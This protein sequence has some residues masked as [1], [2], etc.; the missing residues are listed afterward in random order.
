MFAVSIVGRA[1]VALQENSTFVP[2]RGGSYAEGIIGQPVALNPIISSN[3]T[4]QDISS[5]IYSS[6]KDLLIVTEPTEEGRVYQ[7]KLKNDLVWDDG[8][9]LT[10]DDVLFTIRTVQD[11]QARSPFAQEWQGIVAERISE[12]QIKLTLPTPYA[13][14]PDNIARLRIIPRHIFGTIPVQNLDHS[15]YSLE[16]VGSGPY[17]FKDFSKRRDGFI[18][19]YQLVV[20]ERFHGEPPFIK[21]FSFFF[22]NSLDSLLND[23]KFRKIDG[24][25]LL[26]PPALDEEEFSSAV[27]ETLPMPRYYAVFFNGIGNTILKNV[28]I[29]NALA[30]AIDRVTVTKATF[31]TNAQPFASLSP[32][33]FDLEHASSTRG[34]IGEQLAFAFN[35]ESASVAISEYKKKEKIDVMELTITTPD[36]PFLV[37][38]A[39]D[40]ARAWEMVG[41]DTVTVAPVNMRD[42]TESIIR[43]RNYDVLLFGNVLQNTIDL[44]PFWHSS[45][46]FYPGLNLSLYNNPTVDKYIEAARQTIDI[47]EQLENFESAVFLINRDRP[48]IFL[49]SLPYWYIHTKHLGGF[50]PVTIVTPE[51]RFSNVESWYVA[52][53]RA[54]NKR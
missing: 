47:G 48:A 37:S 26:T 1:A 46:R 11:P 45:Q 40:I 23:F 30:N 31:D 28:S 44:F 32:N 52:R 3:Q 22:Y 8:E 35:P 12:L 24:F 34:F 19:R 49:F 43:T 10:T 53:V 51:S 54:P 38:I 42:L 15:A 16:P 6:L 20:N 9:P 21:D 13:F 33:I 2:V 41:V 18:T 17:R 36:T 27:I 7:L 14:L 29:R 50:E 5:L 4:D 39:T 25:G